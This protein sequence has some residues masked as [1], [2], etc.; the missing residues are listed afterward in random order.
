MYI[1]QLQTFATFFTK[2]V[3]N[4]KLLK[5]GQLWISTFSSCGCVNNKYQSTFL[6]TAFRLVDSS[7][8]TRLIVT[9]WPDDKNWGFKVDVSRKIKY[10]P[11]SICT[12]LLQISSLKYRV[13]WTGFFVYF[14]LEF[15]RLHRQSNSSSN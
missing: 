12:W 9:H 14:K 2:S 3:Q 11:L 15:C 8:K 1:L 5:N 7:F 6:N 10:I 4:C 13:W